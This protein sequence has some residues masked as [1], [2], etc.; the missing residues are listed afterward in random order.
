MPVVLAAGGEGSFLVAPQTGLMIWTLLAF[1]ITLFILRKWAFPQIADALDRRRQRIEDS[2]ETAE[3]T[4]RDA[5]ELLSE[6]RERLK[7]AREQADDIVVRARK[8]GERHE[9]QKKEQARK[10]YEEMLEQAKRDIESER[11]RAVQ[12]LRREVA[13]LT[14]VA[15]EKV[16]RKSLDDDDHRRLVEEALEEADF[17]AL[18]G[19]QASNG[20]GGNR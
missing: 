20:R 1:G 16:T 14:V 7:E 4:R 10:E 2:I 8:N 13:D 5:D 18:A 9:E 17:D 19:E 6:Y 15:A 3:R 11:R 12:D